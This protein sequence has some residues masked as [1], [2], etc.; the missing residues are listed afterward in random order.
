MNMVGIGIDLVD[1]DRL[2]KTLGQHAR[3]KDRLF[4]PAEIAYCES[5]RRP[6]MHYAGRFA[7]KEAIIKALGRAVPWKEME[8]TNDERGKP[9][10]ALSGKA[11][12]L[13]GADRVLVSITHTESHAVA[14]AVIVAD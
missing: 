13:L 4:T 9:A 1:V 6:G 5:K 3:M 14:Q 11:L 12:D 10:A 2:E 8:I 7:V